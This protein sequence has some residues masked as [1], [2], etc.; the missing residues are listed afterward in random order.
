MSNRVFVLGWDGA[1]WDILRPL[2]A[3]GRLPVLQKLMQQGV[4]GTLSSVFPPLS[5]VAWTTVM[6][7]KN[8]GKH[9][10]FAGHHRRPSH[11]TQWR[12]NRAECA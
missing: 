8:S 4:S 9:G 5:P 10:I 11:W 7:G 2:M 3:E 12:K 1:T 6:T